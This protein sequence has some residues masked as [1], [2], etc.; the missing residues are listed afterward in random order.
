M[1]IVRQIGKL[2]RSEQGEWII[3]ILSALE[4]DDGEQYEAMLKRVRGA[5]FGRLVLGVWADRL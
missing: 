2:P 1:W 3:R 4:G 5:V